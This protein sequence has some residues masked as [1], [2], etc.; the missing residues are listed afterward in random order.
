MW[1]NVN[2]CYFNG[3]IPGEIIFDL[4]YN[5]IETMLL[6]HAREQGKQVISGLRMFIEQAVRQ[7]EIWTGESAP[8]A[9]MEAAALDALETR[10]LEQKAS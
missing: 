6:R 8:R 10:Y 3:V 2:D 7:F 5:P 1:P 4:V 9:T